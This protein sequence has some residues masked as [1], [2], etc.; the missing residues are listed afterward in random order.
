MSATPIRPEDLEQL[1]NGVSLSPSP[2]DPPN[3]GLIDPEDLIHRPPAT[4]GARR[5]AWKL[6][7]KWII[8]GSAGLV[9]TLMAL[10]FL[11]S[12]AS[13]FNPRQASVAE[14]EEASELEQLRAAR[15]R[16]ELEANRAKARLAIQ[17]QSARTLPQEAEEPVPPPP[18][19]AAPAANPAPMPVA[20]APVPIARTPAPPAVRTP[21]RP[22]PPRPAP[23][24]APPTPQVDPS[25]QWQQLATGGV[26]VAAAP[27]QV[28]EAPSA[29]AL[30]SP[31]REPVRLGV[32]KVV[33]PGTQGVL[34][35]RAPAPVV[36]PPPP[37]LVLPGTAVSAV[38]TQPV[39][40]NSVSRSAY[41]L[42]LVSLSEALLDDGGAEVLPAGT[43]LV[44][45]V[46]SVAVLSAKRALVKQWATQ[47]IVTREDGTKQLIEIPPQT[48][49]VVGNEDDDGQLIAKSVNRSGGFKRVLG[50][51]LLGAVREV[52]RVAN[53]PESEVIRSG[54][55][56]ST[57]STVNGESDTFAAVLTGVADPLL[58]RAQAGMD[59]DVDRRDPIFLVPANTPVT[60]TLE[61]AWQPN[62]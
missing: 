42:S 17:Q 44:V 56:G 31:S 25:Q 14:T 62:A 54:I 9:V 2:E 1:G 18:P 12:F 57:F 39:I 34:D 47:A 51:A 19:E 61:K 32:E 59:R 15:D 40:Y 10:F 43:Q 60:V 37:A 26:T 55:D 6:G 22:A 13:L 24:P 36:E 52:G 3:Q 58:A 53:R 8:G 16:A 29:P 41:S 23:P 21:P 5:S 30:P 20:A 50:L 7:S 11:S 4:D 28:A 27:L 48:V 49:A 38:Q 45:E 35:G 46:D 33:T